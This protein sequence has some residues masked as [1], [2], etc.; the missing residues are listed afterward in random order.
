[1]WSRWSGSFAPTI[2]A[3]T[4]A[5]NTSHDV[6]AADQLPQKSFGPGAGLGAGGG[7]LWCV[8]PADAI[9]ATS[10]I[11]PTTRS[12]VPTGFECCSSTVLARREIH[13]RGRCAYWTS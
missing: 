3:L 13:V 9:A 1:M 11:T 8:V 12:A 6:A 5:T 7:E 4:A 2:G 10:P